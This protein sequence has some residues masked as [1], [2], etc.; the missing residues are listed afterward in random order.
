RKVADLKKFRRSEVDHLSRKC[1]KGVHEASLFNDD[2]FQAETFQLDSARKTGWSRTNNY[3]IKQPIALHHH[4]LFA[5]QSVDLERQAKDINKSGSVPLI[6]AR[7]HRKRCKIGPVK[8][9]RRR[10]S[11]NYHIALVELELHRTSDRLCELVYE[12]IERLSQWREP[13]SEIDH[14]GIFERQH[15]LVV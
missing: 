10:A 6:L 3:R 12:C 9:A 5:G 11:G 13:L 7:S 2:V 1:E 4:E 14:L 8:C 15:L